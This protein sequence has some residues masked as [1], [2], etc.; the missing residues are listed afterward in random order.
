MDRPSARRERFRIKAPM[1]NSKKV[2]WIRLDAIGDTI[3]AASMLR[4]VYD[5]YGKARITALCE[6]HTAELYQ[7]SPYVERVIA[8]D[9]MKL[10]LDTQYRTDIVVELQKEG[11]DVTLDTTCSWLQMSDL[12]AIGSL[13]KEK[14]AFENVGAVPAAMMEKRRNIFTK[15][16]KFRRPYEPE[17]ERYRDFLEDI[18]IT[19]SSL[20]ATIWT[21]AE[22]DEYADVVFEGNGLNPEKTIALFAFGRSHLRTYRHYGEALRD[23]CRED[24]YSVVALGDGAAYGFNENCLDK[25]GVPTLNLSGKTTLRQ[26]ASILR[27]CRLAVGAE[28]GLAHMACAV[29]TPNVIIIGGGHAGRFMPYTPKTSL[30]T[31]PLECFDCDWNCR[32]TRAHCVSDVAPEVVEHAVRET[33]HR[34]SDKPRIFIH[35]QSGWHKSAGLPEWKFAGKFLAPAEIEVIPVEFE[36][37]SAGNPVDNSGDADERPLAVRTA[38]AKA[39]GLRDE[40]D[41]EGALAILEEAI[42]L[43]GR[44][45]ELVNL[46]AELLM[47]GGKVEEAR[48]L[49]W[50]TALEFPFSV[51]VLN[52]IAVIEIMQRRYDSAIGML[53]RVLEIQPKNETAMA[54]LR[55][56]EG[57][58][59]VRSKLMN[60]EQC[61][62]NEESAAARDALDEILKMYPDHE[63]ALADLAVVEARDGKSGEAVRLLQKVLAFNP[64][65]EFAARLMDKV[66]FG[67]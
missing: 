22:D 13:A 65:N 5:H 17:M 54:N 66:L 43:N 19:A 53:Q 58:L 10:Y 11:F 9:K 4:P 6:S 26:T 42:G 45:P 16:V 67:G 63:D 32:F 37:R 59:A 52:N 8:V 40:A 44:F 29:G 38:L 46:K 21:T 60:A 64:A 62:M 1:T 23:I 50:G 47:Q 24:G 14:F 48:E 20:D 30:V 27:K 31:L 49:L 55:F 51:D 41:P 36:P 25:I 61:I 34:S 28:T 3:L 12:F 18:G 56:I 39:V 2:L 7:A 35:P 57:E 15:L 33:L